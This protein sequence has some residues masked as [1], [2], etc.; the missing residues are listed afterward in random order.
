MEDIDS[1]L[2]KSVQFLKKEF[3]SLQTGRANSMLVEDFEIEA[4]GAKQPLKHAANISVPDGQ[5]IMIDPWDKTLLADIEKAIQQN[6]NFSFSISNDGSAIRLNVPPLTEERRK[7]IAKLVHTMAEKGRISVRNVRHEEHAKLKKQKE[8]GEISEDEFY[9][10]EKHL[11]EKVDNT[12]KKID[13]ITKKKE[14]EVMT[15]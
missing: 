6:P 3:A 8:E 10:E 11:Q 4:Y 12:N 14:A 13:E 9:S 15:V 1:L 7:E 5:T 2:Q